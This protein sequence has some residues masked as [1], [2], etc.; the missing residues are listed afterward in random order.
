M[1][2]QKRVTCPRFFWIL[3][4]KQGF[5]SFCLGFQDSS[6]SYSSRRLFC[7]HARAEASGIPGLSDC[8]GFR[9]GSRFLVWLKTNLLSGIEYFCR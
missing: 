2:M 8:M 7:M 6:S 9:N 3:V 5:S 1:H 4:F